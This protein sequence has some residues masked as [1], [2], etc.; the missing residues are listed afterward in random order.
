MKS[1]AKLWEAWRL[2][3]TYQQL[4]SQIYGVEDSLASYCFDRAV[5]TFGIAVEQDIEEATDGKKKKAAEASA[6]M[7]RARWL[8]TDMK[9]ANPVPTRR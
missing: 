6:S 8:G 3:K 1:S 7:V 9:F 5:A 4:P 2:S